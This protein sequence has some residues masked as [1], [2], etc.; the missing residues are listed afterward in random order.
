MLKL[1][2]PMLLCTVGRGVAASPTIPL[3]Y[4]VNDPLTQ[5]PDKKYNEVCTDFLPSFYPIP[6]THLH[7][8]IAQILFSL[9]LSL[10]ARRTNHSAIIGPNPSVR[11]GISRENA[12]MSLVQ[13]A[14]EMINE[15]GVLLS[16]EE[17]EEGMAKEIGQVLRVC[18]HSE[19]SDHSRIS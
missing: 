8:F 19:F 18:L 2:F 12:C 9:L 5:W 6:F 4:I 13:R 14:C 1:I 15:T 17:E 7:H 16:R 3:V 10:G 11:S